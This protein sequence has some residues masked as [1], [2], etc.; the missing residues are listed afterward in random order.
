MSIEDQ[1]EKT[2]DALCE[3][4]RDKTR[5]TLY[6]TR[7]RLII[8]MDTPDRYPPGAVEIGTYT[9]TVK[10]EDFREDVFHAFDSMSRG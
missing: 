4:G 2:W 3:L 7:S 8:G 5:R 1:I 9:R 6:L 10:L